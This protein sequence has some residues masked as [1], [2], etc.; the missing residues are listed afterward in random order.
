MKTLRIPLVIFLLVV[1]GPTF[2]A[3]ALTETILYSFGS[4]PTDGLNPIAPLVQ[5]S[6]GNFY[7]TTFLQGSM[8][9]IS[10]SGT[11]TQL[12]SFA[13]FP[14]AG[15]VQGSDGNFYGTT[16]L[17]GTY[18]TGTVFRIS[19]GGTYTSLYSFGGSPTDGAYPAAGLV[20]GSDGNFYGTTFLG[21][22][23]TNCSGGCGTVFQISPSG[24]ETTLYSFGSFP[25][26]GRS[27]YAGL[28]VGDGGNF[29][30]T[31]SSGGTSTNIN[32]YTDEPGE[33]TVFRISPSGDYASL[34]SFGSFPTDGRS[35]YA[36]L[37]VGDDGNF[38]GTTLAGGTHN[39]GTVFRISPSGDY[40]NLYSFGSFHADGHSPYAGLVQGSDGNFYGTTVGGGTGEKYGAPT[41]VFEP[42]DGTVFR[43]SPGGNYTS[44]YS[45]GRSPTDGAYPVAG[46]VQGSDSNFYGTTFV[47][48][49]YDKSTR[50]GGTVFVFVLGGGG[51]S[52]GTNCTY[53]L[54]ATNVTLAAKGGSKTVSVKVKGTDCS[55]W[56]AVS[57][58]PFI[59]ITSGSSVTGN[60]KVEY[61]VPGN[62]NTTGLIGM[63]TIA[64]QTFTVNQNPGGCTYKLS[65]KDKKFKAA[66]GIGTV[67]VTP[68]FG[69]CDWTAVSTNSLITITD[70]STNEGKGTVTYTV[71]ANTTSTVLTGSM[72][73]AGETFTVVQAG[74]R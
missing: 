34:Y 2:Y 48:G 36:G 25:T 31:T 3:N 60:G 53:T 37:V 67:K 73:V 44:L 51:G 30:G 47:G 58:D 13:G 49:T 66:G 33:G 4:S 16:S 15:L 56:T 11:Y 72:I 71:P 70:V 45:F 8:F 55:S 39:T 7:G 26:D 18:N 46:L 22:S 65:P 27:P 1:T 29:Y 62:T 64:G 68:N 28:V 61:T 59:T 57:N 52:G 32:T 74:V 42:G 21:G 69:D 24:T 63:M 50:K 6:D 23:N 9:R 12:C 35:P 40:T 41:P 54:N 10:S 38:Y 20:Q 43:I 19:P 14:Y 5:G 17:G